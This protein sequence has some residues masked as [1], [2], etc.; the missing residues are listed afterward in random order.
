MSTPD[1]PSGTD[2][3]AVEVGKLVVRAHQGDRAAE[4]ALIARTRPAVLRMLERRMGN[5]SDAEDC[6]Q[7]ALEIVLSRIRGVGLEH[8]ETVGAF[9]VATARNVAIAHRRLDARRKTTPDSD[10]IDATADASPGFVDELDRERLGRAVRELV[11]ELPL[12]RDRDLLVRHYLL[13]ESRESLCA[14]YDLDPPHLARVL[15]R[16]RQRFRE[17]LERSGSKLGS[18]EIGVLMLLALNPGESGPGTRTADTLSGMAQ[19]SIAVRGVLH[20]A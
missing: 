9:I 17:I 11:N 13:D 20:G 5:R 12:A 6:T 7:E 14:R 1:D 19:V 8:P 10:A 15:H 18:L 4:S 16:A 3:S 2:A